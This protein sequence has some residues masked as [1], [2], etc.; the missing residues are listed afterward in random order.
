M[1]P[2]FLYLSALTIALSA[3]H[4]LAKNVSDATIETQRKNLEN[5]SAGHGFGPQ[6]PRNI[7]NPIGNNARHFSK[8]LPYR[9]MNLCNIHFHR[10]AEHKGGEFTTYA[11]NGDEDGVGGGYRYNG[12]LADTETQPLSA[13]VCASEEGALNPGDT[14]EIHY[15]YSSADI[16]PGKSLKSCFNDSTSNPQLRVEAQVFV[17]VNDDSAQDFTKLTELAEVNGYQQAPN[18]PNDT[19]T[20]VEYI[21]STTGPVYNE[22]ASPFEVTWAVRPKVAKVNALTVGKWCEGNPF[23][24]DHAHGVRNLVINPDLLSPIK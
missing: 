15:V 16:T 5:N 6:S 7:D 10:N 18:I 22:E 24:E 14:I 8:A 19:G 1:K 23:E 12:S 4:A 17:L 20:P 3:G 21:G 13:P 9:E 2:P 11:G